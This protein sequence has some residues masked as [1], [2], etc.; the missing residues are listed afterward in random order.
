MPL[1][2]NNQ[3]KG[4]ALSTQTK[5]QLPASEQQTALQTGNQ[6]T[7]RGAVRGQNSL[8]ACKKR[9]A[10]LT[11]PGPSQRQRTGFAP[12]EARATLPETARQ[13]ALQLVQEHLSCP[14]PLASVQALR[15]SLPVLCPAAPAAK[16][17]SHTP[18]QS[19]PEPYLPGTTVRTIR[20]LFVRSAH[21]AAAATGMQYDMSA[22]RQRL[23]APA[24]SCGQGERAPKQ[25]S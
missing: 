4:Y 9:V 19:A 13:P 2:G 23:S 21:K 14:A 24:D 16:Q 10:D 20:E 18:T 3:R 22:T 7:S 5:V 6:K 1:Y 12:D 25:A 17:A 15:P 8:Q 11:Q